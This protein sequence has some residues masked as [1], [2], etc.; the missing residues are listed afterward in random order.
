MI[1]MDDFLERIQL[2]KRKQIKLPVDKGKFIRVFK[3]NIDEGE[4]GIFSGMFEAFSS[5]ENK[6]KGNISNND[7]EIR[8]RR[9]LFQRNNQFATINGTF[10][11]HADH[12]VVD[13][14]VN[15][16]S[17]MLI[18]FYLFAIIFYIIFIGSAN[19]SQPFEA[20]HLFI[21][22]HAILIFAIP[23]FVMRRN[24]KRTMLDI[25]KELLFMTREKSGMY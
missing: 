15:G 25:E 22:V 14:S 1:I 11:Q 4:I 17:K 24:V 13:L 9:V 21:V 16:F 18:P 7:F 2:I 5:S 20:F 3:Q 10:R 23:Y 19:F 12:V 8:R 6:Y